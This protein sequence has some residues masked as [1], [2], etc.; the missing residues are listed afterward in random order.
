MRSSTSDVPPSARVSVPASGIAIAGLM[1]VIVSQ[2]QFA[3][4]SQ[5]NWAVAAWA[6]GL[7]LT[8]IAIRTVSRS[9][10]VQIVDVQIVDDPLV[11]RAGWSS[12]HTLVPASIAIASCIVSWRF[13]HAEPVTARSGALLSI[14][15][16]GVVCTVATVTQ[17]LTM[18]PREGLG[19][20]W[21]RRRGEVAV[22]CAF[23]GG[24]AVL[25]L[26]RLA[27]DPWTFQGDEG[28]FA[29]I[30]SQVLDGQIANPF[31]LGYMSHPM[32]YN[33]LQAAAMSITG[34]TV[35]GARLVSALLGACSVPL[36]YLFTKRLVGKRWTGVVAAL[37]LGTFHAQ[38]YWSRSALPN[39]ASIFFVLLVLYLLDRS[40]N[41][42]GPAALLLTGVSA[43]LAQYFYFSNRV[44]VPTVVV[45]L[46]AAAVT[47]AVT[48]R[49]WKVTA[50]VLGKRLALAAAGFVAAVVPLAA[51]YD[52]HPGQFNGRVDQVSLF[53]GDTL[54]FE[55]RATGRSHLGVLWHHLTESAMLPFRTVPQGFYRGDVPSMGWAIA[56]AGA[57]GLAL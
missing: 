2:F 31:S 50:M 43:G 45:V 56:I 44:L 13:Q 21:Q 11:P 29:V 49:R 32:L 7:V 47:N 24:G 30:S 39:G 33:E 38:L 41:D 18:N 20:W 8:V 15:A 37:L 34:R 5:S 25:T 14:W 16:I 40:L 57:V 51:F 17:P 9:I 36:A 28:G 26:T 46:L 53:A 3:H 23:A 42:G 4:R 1:L 54:E 52:Q 27:S 55:A 19:A 6:V 35:F 22:L 10:E 48:G 12:P